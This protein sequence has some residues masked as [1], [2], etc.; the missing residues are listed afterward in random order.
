MGSTTNLPKTGENNCL[1]CRLRYSYTRIP[2][3]A[4]PVEKAGLRIKRR[5]LFIAPL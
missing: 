2:Q 3:T 5:P 4:E 1:I